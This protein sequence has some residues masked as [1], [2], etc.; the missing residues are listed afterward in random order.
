MQI[1]VTWSLLAAGVARKCSLPLRHLCGQPKIR[2]GMTDEEGEDE[3][4]SPFWNFA[5]ALS[6]SQETNGFSIRRERLS[7]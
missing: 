7:L 5:N 2:S 4:Y 1:T 3:Y 6:V